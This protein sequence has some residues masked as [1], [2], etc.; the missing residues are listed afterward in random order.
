MPTLDLVATQH[1]EANFR[2]R[3]MPYDKSTR[4]RQSSGK[5]DLLLSQPSSLFST[6]VTSIKADSQ[7]RQTGC[8]QSDAARSTLLGEVPPLT[9]IFFLTA[10]PAVY[11][12]R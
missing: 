3:F 1:D 7:A 2:A 8:V 10:N 11:I 4:N 5:L 6:L 9:P 12:D